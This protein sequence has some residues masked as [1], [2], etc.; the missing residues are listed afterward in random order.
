MIGL[1]QR[2]APCYPATSTFEDSRAGTDRKLRGAF[3]GTFCSKRHHLAPFCSGI[4]LRRRLGRKPQFEQKQLVTVNRGIAQSG[5]AE[6]LGALGRLPYKIQ[7]IF[8]NHKRLATS[9]RGAILASVGFFVGFSV[10][11]TAS[12]EVL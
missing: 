4:P 7:H 12:L 10:A 3:R 5:S 2:S 9:P 8:I 1:Q 6:V 11:A